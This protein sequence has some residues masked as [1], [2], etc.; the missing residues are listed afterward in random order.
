M[1]SRPGHRE[2]TAQAVSTEEDEAIV[3][4]RADRLVD[5]RERAVPG[6]DLVDARPVGREVRGDDLDVGTQPHG[7]PMPLGSTELRAVHEDEANRGLH[8]AI[9]A[10]SAWMSP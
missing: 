3:R 7:I 8:P 6:E 9:I 4:D 2:I 10:R 1:A 5:H